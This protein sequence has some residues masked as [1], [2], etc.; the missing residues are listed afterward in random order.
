MESP[1]PIDSDR[2]RDVEHRL[3]DALLEEAC[4]DFTIADERRI[5]Q[6]MDS[7]HA[8]PMSSDSTPPVWRTYGPWTLA[9]SVLIAIASFAFFSSR[10]SQAQTRVTKCLQAPSKQREYRLEIIRSPQSNQISTTL[11][12]F[13]DQNRFVLQ[14]PGFLGVGATWIGGDRSRRWILPPRG[15]VA[16]GDEI[17]LGKWLTKR[18]L[19]SPYLQLESVLVQL[20]KGYTLSE[21][22]PLPDDELARYPHIEGK[23]KGSNPALPQQIDLWIDPDTEYV[24][25]LTLQWNLESPN[26]HR[27]WNL[28][29]V[30]SPELPENWFEYEGHWNMPRRVFTIRSLRALEEWVPDGE[31]EGV[32][33]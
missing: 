19:E 3:L 5:E 31:N 11:A 25:R 2:K 24:Y 12:L 28:Q 1:K 22:A 9:A 29:Y 26:A 16:V 27:I 10:E 30:G 6:L 20:K 7:L 4:T 17:F 21:I 33:P 32:R 23:R 14:H 15:P 18:N 13:V 8:K